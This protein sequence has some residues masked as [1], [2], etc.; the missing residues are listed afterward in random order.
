M[1]GSRLGVKG[2]TLGIMQHIPD[3]ATFSRDCAVSRIC[4][5]KSA[6]LS[7]PLP[8][9]PFELVQN[10]HSTLGAHP[11]QVNTSHQCCHISLLN[12]FQTSLLLRTKQY[13]ITLWLSNHSRLDQHFNLCLQ[14]VQS[15]GAVCCDGDH[16]IDDRF[17]MQF[18]ALA[19][20]DGS[21]APPHCYILHC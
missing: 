5:L 16:S 20:H 18:E 10:S 19:V 21:I 15:L 4:C 17:C 6:C 3:A 14:S 7:Q 9:P 1:N 8:Q 11:K 12:D 2:L 13:M